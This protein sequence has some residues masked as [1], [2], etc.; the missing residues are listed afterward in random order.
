MVTSNTFCAAASAFALAAARSRFGVVVVTLRVSSRVSSTRNLASRGGAR[1]LD[2]DAHLGRE[3]LVEGELDASAGVNV[4]EPAEGEVD[5]DGRAV[6]QT[7]GDDGDDLLED[8]R[9]ASFVDAAALR[10]RFRAQVDQGDEPSLPLRDVARHVR[11]GSLPHDS[12]AFAAVCAEINS[13]T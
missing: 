7:L 8:V 1:A 5:V 10:E 2:E 9:R 4:V 11:D 12:Y 6:E 13:S 3:G